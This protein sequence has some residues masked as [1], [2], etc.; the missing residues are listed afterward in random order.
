MVNAEN[1]NKLIEYRMNKFEELEKGKIN[2]LQFAE[3]NFQFLRQNRLKP[4]PKAYDKKSLIYNY[5]YWMIYIERKISIEKQLIEAVKKKRLSP[6]AAGRDRLNYLI[7]FYCKRRNQAV[8]RLI[9]EVKLPV[10]KAILLFNDI[11]EIN[12]LDPDLGENQEF[13]F[14]MYCNK[15][16]LDPFTEINV[17][18]DMS[19][20]ENYV[21]MINLDYFL[22]DSETL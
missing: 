2:L 4:V 8:Q 18:F 15:K 6:E 11:V 21:K 1:Y 19:T 22:E 16:I 9:R 12:F 3:R 10:K 17:E 7:R 5:L 14:K 20:E 13:I